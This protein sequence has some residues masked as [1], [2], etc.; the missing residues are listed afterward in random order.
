MVSASLDKFQK[1]YTTIL[2][3][4]VGWVGNDVTKIEVEA[5]DAASKTNFF[6]YRYGVTKFGAA[7]QFNAN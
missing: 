7:D 3:K 6:R 1:S 2:N 4:K 5:K